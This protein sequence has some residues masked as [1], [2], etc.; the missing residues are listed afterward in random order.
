MIVFADPHK[1]FPYG[2]KELPRRP[3]ILQEYEAE[4][5]AAYATSDATPKVV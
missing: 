4:I 1:P 3:A 5:H 2:I